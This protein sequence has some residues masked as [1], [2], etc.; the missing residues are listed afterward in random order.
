MLDKLE[1]K[2]KPLPN[3]EQH[4]TPGWIAA[5]IV[6]TARQSGMLLNKRILDLGSGV[7]IFCIASLL[8]GASECI[9]IEID[10]DSIEVQRR[11]LAMYELQ[12]DAHVILG[13]AK[14]LPLRESICDLALMNPPFGTVKKGDDVAFLYSAVS[15][16]RAA[17][18][19][20]LSSEKTR[21]FI[22]R[23]MEKIGKKS[24]VL[25]T[26]KMELKQIFEYHRSRIKRIS[27]DLY[28]VE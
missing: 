10:P 15:A 2:L 17:L 18:S 5:D 16:C 19:L 28:L 6:W 7:G 21:E 25:K 8:A 26:Y 23:E 12:D 3:L 22:Y 11:N 20:H 13:D 24:K 9:S 4:R 27:V 1:G 14:H